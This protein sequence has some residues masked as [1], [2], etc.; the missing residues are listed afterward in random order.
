MMRITLSIVFVL[1]SVLC[2]AQP[3][4]DLN[5]LSATGSG[6]FAYQQTDKDSV[7][8]TAGDTITLHF[9]PDFNEKRNKPYGHPEMWSESDSTIAGVF[10]NSYVVHIEIQVTQE[11][12]NASRLQQFIDIGE[13][14]PLL[15]PK[16]EDFVRNSGD[17]R[18]F[19]TS[20]GLYTLDT[21]EANGG[22]VRV[23]S[24]QNISVK[25]TRIVC[26]LT[27]KGHSISVP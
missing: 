25:L 1:L 24:D 16:K 22:K 27:H 4:P 20:T 26:Q 18:S 6:Y 7:L 15:Y 9:N 8:L 14:I 5:D 19:G 11:T 2:F 10:G 23:T 3:G 21:W 12:N 13:G 17:T